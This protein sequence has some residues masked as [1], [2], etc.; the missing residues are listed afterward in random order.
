[1]IQDDSTPLYDDHW[2]VRKWDF[3]AKNEGKMTSENKVPFDST[4]IALCRSAVYFDSSYLSCRVVDLNERVLY[5]S[6]SHTGK[7]ALYDCVTVSH[8]LKKVFVFQSASATQAFAPTTGSSIYKLS[9]HK[10]HS[11]MENL[12]LLQSGYEMMYIYC[13]GA[14]DQSISC[15]VTVD[16]DTFGDNPCSAEMMKQIKE[17]FEIVIA[18]VSF[19]PN[20]TDNNNMI[21]I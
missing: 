21:N 11:I 3:Y 6:H 4:G 2:T 1:M 14:K 16:S 19:F 12:K 15:E 20:L 9:I 13:C 8:S 17:S 5:I 7:G 18:R 10:I